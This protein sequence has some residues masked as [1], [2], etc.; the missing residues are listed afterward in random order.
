MQIL[1]GG[2]LRVIGLRDKMA[3]ERTVPVTKP[4]TE[5]IAGRLRKVSPRLVHAVVQRRIA[6]ALGAWADASRLGEVGTEWELRLGM[7]DG[8]HDV[9]VA[10][11]AYLSY[12]RAAG[13]VIAQTPRIAP[14]VAVE[15]R[16]PDE[17]AAR[18]EEKIRR[19]LAAGT[20]RV[21][22]VD[23]SRKTIVNRAR[24]AR[25]RRCGVGRAFSDDALPGFSLDLASVFAFPAVRGR[26]RE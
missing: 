2:E 22:D 3:V 13:N 26:S 1:R 10:D 5:R 16:S 17:S 15:I 24:D 25:S 18:R 4:A 6:A 19:Y 7:P 14:D 9:L 20:V 11:V 21:W 23:P 12:A 8:S